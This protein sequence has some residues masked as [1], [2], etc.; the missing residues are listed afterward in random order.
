[1]FKNYRAGLRIQ[2]GN[3]SQNKRLNFLERN[4]YEEI[5]K[6]REQKGK[7]RDQKRAEKKE[8]KPYL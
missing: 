8:R 5:R 3:I 6:E 7:G 4:R 1:L 2:P